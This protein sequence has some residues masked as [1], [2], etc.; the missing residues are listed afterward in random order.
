MTRFAAR[1]LAVAA[2]TGIYLL[3]LASAH[4]ADIAVG[5][6]LAI[7]ALAVSRPLLAA[8]APSPHPQRPPGWRRALAAPWFAWG[9]A[10]EIVSGTWQVLG[11]ALGLRRLG[12][13]GIVG[14][15]IGQRSPLG[16]TVSAM[17]TTLSPGTTLVAID[18]AR[19]VFWL[20]VLDAR[21]PDGVRAAHERF[22]ERYQRGIFP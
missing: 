16:V 2:L 20:H 19:G 15:P 3:V 21:D 5:A 12:R 7:G 18:H 6:L 11:Y 13:S 17:V 9:A 14:I 8:T 22:Y 1:L 4:P 10:R